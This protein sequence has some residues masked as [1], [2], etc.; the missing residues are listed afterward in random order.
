MLGD[1]TKY[2]RNTPLPSAHSARTVDAL[3]A[4]GVCHPNPTNTDFTH[5]DG[6][7]VHL[8]SIVDVIAPSPEVSAVGL[9]GVV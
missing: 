5:L 7:R 1:Y 4:R 8:Q 2:F 3:L 9:Q 6:A